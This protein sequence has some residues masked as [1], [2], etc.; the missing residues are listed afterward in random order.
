MCLNSKY[1]PVFIMTFMMFLVFITTL[2]VAFLFHLK[3]S[4]VGM[5]VFPDKPVFFFLHN[6]DVGL[7][8]I[9]CQVMQPDTRYLKTQQS[10]SNRVNLIRRVLLYFIHSCDISANQC[11][12]KFLVSNSKSNIFESLLI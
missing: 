3:Q 2:F 5:M 9:S 11:S 6:R 7:I 8:F 1:M 12:Y 4:G 10:A